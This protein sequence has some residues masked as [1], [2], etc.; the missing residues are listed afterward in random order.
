MNFFY[1]EVGKAK[2]FFQLSL[3]KYFTYRSVILTWALIEIVTFTSAIF[4]WLA[5]YQN[6]N[7]VAGYSGKEM[8]FYYAFL[9]LVGSL[10]SVYL[11]TFFPQQIKNGKISPLLLRPYSLP[12]SLFIKSLADL[13]IRQVF[14][15]SLFIIYLYG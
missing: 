1:R 3:S 9:P 2:V 8:L 6:Q 4:L 14:K 12:W 13:I 7:Q 11:S 10:T 5:V 15:L